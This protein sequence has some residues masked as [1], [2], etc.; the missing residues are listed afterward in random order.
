M[1]TA[2]ETTATIKRKRELLLDEDLPETTENKVR[3]IVLIKDESDI[4]ESTWLE[5][6]RKNE[7]FDFLNDEKEDI[8]S[9]DDGKP[10]ANE[11]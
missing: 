8:Y 9:P 1:T 4:S 2:I 6:A 7:V 3:V 5:S 11:I 10:I